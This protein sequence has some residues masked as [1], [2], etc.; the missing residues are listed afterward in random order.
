MESKVFPQDVSVFFRVHVLGLVAAH[1]TVRVPRDL[2]SALFAGPVAV[3]LYVSLL[4]LLRRGRY[5]V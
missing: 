3:S 2:R 5:G 4:P 1:L